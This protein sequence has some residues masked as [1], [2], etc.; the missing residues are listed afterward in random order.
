MKIRFQDQE[1]DIDLDSYEDEVLH[2]IISN[3]LP[4]FLGLLY[5][6]KI[7]LPFEFLYD[8]MELMELPEYLLDQLGDWSRQPVVTHHDLQNWLNW[9]NL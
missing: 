1:V 6:L 9:A 4:E 8:Q 7:Q 3:H 2:W 5:K